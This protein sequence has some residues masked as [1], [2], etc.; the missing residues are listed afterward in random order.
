M[1][2][3]ITSI[4]HDDSAIVAGAAGSPSSVKTP[5]TELRNFIRL[6]LVVVSSDA[7]YAGTLEEL[8]IAG[9][10]I[11]L[12]TQ[13]DGGDETLT[14]ALD[15][16]IPTTLD[17]TGTAGEDLAIRD[18]VYLNPTDNKWYK[19]DSDASSSVAMG[20]KRGFATEAISTDATGAIRLNGALSGFTGLTAGMPIY[21]STT[22]GSYTQTKPTASTG[23]SQ[24]VV[25][26][27][28]FALST[29]EVFI[30][31]SGL[32]YVKK[33]SMDD[34]DVMTIEH[35]AD[36]KAY[37]RKVVVMIDE[38]T[39]YTQALCG[40]WGTALSIFENRFDDG[41]LATPTTMTHIRNSTGG[42]SV[43]EVAVIF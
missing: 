24:I 12:T 43:A 27:M 31:P 36:A 19:Q 21:A 7:T 3:L 8:L 17:I 25:S 32:R 18:M 22:A 14:I 37:Q 15:S 40:E 39:Y 11:D 34:T 20:V 33:A 35:H 26:E 29:T 5:L 6:G 38:T 1:S 4:D 16:S 9:D 42:T 41:A 2:T 28:G 10:G 23:G 13:N 30:R